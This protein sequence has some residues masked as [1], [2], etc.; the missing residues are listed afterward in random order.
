MQTSRGSFQ[1]YCK[2]LT[3]NAR[4]TDAMKINENVSVMLGVILYLSFYYLLF[5][6][7]SLKIVHIVCKINIVSLQ[8]EIC[9]LFKPIW[10][11][12][13]DC[14]FKQ[15]VLFP[16]IVFMTTHASL[17][18]CSNLTARRIIPCLP[19]NVAIKAYNGVEKD[20]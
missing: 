19:C 12:H 2:V 1:G 14:W 5:A 17:K 10:I 13:H 7:L 8:N 9:L 3:S 20:F 4:H 15:N 16:L 6:S 18:L 11:F